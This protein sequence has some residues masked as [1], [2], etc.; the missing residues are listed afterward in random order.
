MKLRNVYI[1]LCG[2]GILLPYSQFLPWLQA[3]GL[4]LR[5]FVSE[6]FVTRV[7]AFFGFDVFV[8]A[9]VLFVFIAVEGRRTAPRSRW[10]PVVATLACG[11]SA[12]LPLFHY[13]RQRS[14]DADSQ[15]QV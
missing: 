15:I 13:L 14:L 6:L 12:G 4:D 9:V 3:N 11:V 10:L 8:S 7:G 2:I 5:L 1:C